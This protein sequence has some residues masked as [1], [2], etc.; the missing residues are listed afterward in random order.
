[1]VDHFENF[2]KYI[3][4]N[5]NCVEEVIDDFYGETNRNK[6]YKYTCKK[7][8]ASFIQRLTLFGQLINKNNIYD[9]KNVFG[10]SIDEFEKFK[11]QT[12]TCNENIIKSII[13]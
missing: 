7:C 10:S 13:E 6:V 12:L 4:T 11:K 1:M 3:K 9:L 2:V 8:S 5:H